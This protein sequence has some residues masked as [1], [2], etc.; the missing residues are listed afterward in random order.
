MEYPNLA[1]KTHD[2]PKHYRNNKSQKLSRLCGANEP[3]FMNP[4]VT[5][6]TSLTRPYLCMRC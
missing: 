4:G 3:L 2:L 1:Y 5:T 6:L